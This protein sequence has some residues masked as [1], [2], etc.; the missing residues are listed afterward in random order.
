NCAAGDIVAAA[1]TPILRER[2][3]LACSAEAA[4]QRQGCLQERTVG[5][6]L[7]VAAVGVRIAECQKHWS[8]RK[9]AADFLA[10]EGDHLRDEGPVAGLVELMGDR[11]EVVPE[12]MRKQIAGENDESRIRLD[13][14]HLIERALEESPG[15][16]PT[17]AAVSVGRWF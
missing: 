2:S 12:A 13:L 1:V 3:I 9:P 5:C 6:Q 4:G 11:C 15:R 14:L 8:A 17:V 10:D 7:I 16:V